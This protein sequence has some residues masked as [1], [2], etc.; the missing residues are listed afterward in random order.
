M[1]SPPAPPPPLSLRQSSRRRRGQTPPRPIRT[2]T[3]MMDIEYE[4]DHIVCHRRSSKS[5]GKYMVKWKNDGS[6]HNSYIRL[7]QF[8]DPGECLQD[9]LLSGKVRLH[10]MPAGYESSSSSEANSNEHLHLISSAE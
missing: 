3:P 7:S 10:R 8:N 6:A 2:A 5:G 4:I 9:Y 1:N